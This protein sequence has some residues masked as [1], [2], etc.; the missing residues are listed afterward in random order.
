MTKS[1]YT[2]FQ[3]A[4]VKVIRKEKKTGFSLSYSFAQMLQSPT[5]LEYAIY[6][7]IIISALNHQLVPTTKPNSKD[8]K[9]DSLRRPLVQISPVNKPLPQRIEDE[10]DP[11]PQNTVK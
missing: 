3:Q 4:Q 1:P 6:I 5:I 2:G 9:V 10:C 7:F 11:D 8:A